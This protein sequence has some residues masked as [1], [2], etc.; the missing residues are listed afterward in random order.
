MKKVHTNRRELWR[1]LVS[2]SIFDVGLGDL[3]NIWEI[4]HFKK[5][6]KN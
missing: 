3:L 6:D 5:N 4:F 2:L 1:T